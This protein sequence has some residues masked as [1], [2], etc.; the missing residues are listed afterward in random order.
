VLWWKTLRSLALKGRRCESWE[1]IVRA[2]ERTT[3][4]WNAHRRPSFWSR[5]RRPQARRQPSI[6]LLPNAA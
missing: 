6:A 1:E 4:Y 5:Q 3:T 2:V